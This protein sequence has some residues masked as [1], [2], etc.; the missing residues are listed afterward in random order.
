MTKYLKLI[1]F[2][3]TVVLVA[4]VQ[5]ALIKGL[6]GWLQYLNAVLVIMVFIIGS[7]SLSKALKWAAGFG[8]VLDIFSFSLFGIFTV[9]LLATT[10]LTWFVLVNFLTN[11]SLYSFLAATVFA[12]FC[13]EVLSS[14]ILYFCHIFLSLEN[15]IG[16][17]RY[18]IL[19]KLYGL[20]INLAVAIVV[21][22]FL[23]ILS[24]RYKP[25]FLN[26]EGSI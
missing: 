6:P 4:V 13:F 18:F 8:L 3:L 16:L 7:R 14:T 23:T 17:D 22:N 12:T 25:V 2:I 10:V 11:R 26:K 21:F 24:R 1:P 20:V 9:S 15:F 5:I 19:V